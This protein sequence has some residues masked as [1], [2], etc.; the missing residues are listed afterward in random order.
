MEKN[1][2][3]SSYFKTWLF[4]F[5][6]VILN[7]WSMCAMSVLKFKVAAFSHKSW[8]Y[9]HLNFLCFYF[10]LLKDEFISLFPINRSH[11]LKNTFKVHVIKCT[12]KSELLSILINERCITR[13]TYRSLFYFYFYCYFFKLYISFF[14]REYLQL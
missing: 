5:A 12:L 14:G 8:N 10:K 9:F 3:I 6:N 4:F 7:G 13:D 2:R 1:K 11:I